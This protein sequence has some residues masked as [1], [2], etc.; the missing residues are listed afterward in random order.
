MVSSRNAERSFIFSFVRAGFVSFF[1]F[2]LF[3]I[4]FGFPVSFKA[5]VLYLLSIL[6]I[7][8]L[9]LLTLPLLTSFATKCPSPSTLCG[10]KRSISSSVKS[11]CLSKITQLHPSF[12][13]FEKVRVLYTLIT[14]PGLS[15]TAALSSISFCLAA[16]IAHIFLCSTCSIALRQLSKHSFS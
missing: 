14:P 6:D 9:K 5:C 15:I 8:P 10:Q 3:F 7:K 2:L 12:S 16:Q 4:L 11:G 13:S 1:L